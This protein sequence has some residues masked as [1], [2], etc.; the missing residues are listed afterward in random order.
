[1]STTPSDIATNA[2]Q[3]QPALAVAPHPAAQPTTGAAGS[4][5]VTAHPAAA[6]LG[7]SPI[8]SAHAMTMYASHWTS[9]LHTLIAQLQ[10]DIGV[11][12]HRR[13]RQHAVAVAA[14]AAAAS[15]A[16]AAAVAGVG[17]GQHG[18]RTTGHA[19]HSSLAAFG[20]SQHQLQ[21]ELNGLGQPHSSA[22]PPAPVSDANSIVLS[23]DTATS[24]WPALATAIAAGAM[25][26][27]TSAS[28]LPSLASGIGPGGTG[29]ASGTTPAGNR[30]SGSLLP[31]LQRRI[32]SRRG[33][34][35]QDVLALSAEEAAHTRTQAALAGEAAEQQEAED[36]VAAAAAA[37]VAAAAAAGVPPSPRHQQQLSLGA[38][39]HYHHHASHAP[40]GVPSAASFGA[41][42]GDSLVAGTR[43]ALHA[44]LPSS[45]SVTSG[46]PG[47]HTSG[48]THRRG[49]AGAS[50]GALQGPLSARGADSQH[51]PPMLMRNSM[52]AVESSITSEIA[53]RMSDGG[54]PSEIQHSEPLPNGSDERHHT[55]S[56][57]T[58]GGR[59]SYAGSTTDML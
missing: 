25:P 52:G 20:L 2:Q 17:G 49:P 33:D 14:R 42:L 11:Q 45:Q 9:H 10:W 8:P 47:H 57:R 23:P 51:A 19:V 18:S 6:G 46:S 44:A 48:R 40:P 3:Q 41:V 16:S 15:S 24:P 39:L 36:A 27:S 50:S 34:A 54:G 38:H 21:Q 13:R 31:G 5:A 30:S 32:S 22:L 12:R 56:A 26:T 59:S 43:G 4:P 1:V 53:P 29:S 55:L 35:I 37:A 7:L 58:A 28:Q